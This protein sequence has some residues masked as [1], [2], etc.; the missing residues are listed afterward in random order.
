MDAA[1]RGSLLHDALSRFFDHAAGR[2]GSPVLLRAEH[3]A[4]AIPLAEQ[5]LDEALEDAR[6]KRWLGSELL[7][8]PK[9]LEL[10]RI[11]R[12]YL[13]WEI[14]Q[15]ER[16]FVSGRGGLPRRIR[17]GVHSHEMVLGEIEFCRGD[18]RIKFRGFVDRVEVGIDTRFD[19]G[20][21]VAAVDYK[22]TVWSCP[23]A[24]KGA[25]WTDGVVLQVP[26]Y[27]EALKARF[28]G[29]KTARVE[30]RAL[31]GKK[32]VHQLELY[33]FDKNSHRAVGDEE[34]EAKLEAALDAVADHVRT[35][36]SG[37][38]PVRPAESCGCPSFCHAIEICRVAGGPKTG[39]WP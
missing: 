4:A 29:A 30:Y 21:Y 26:L 20:C 24:G 5:S 19:A 17:T 7:L 13:E 10:W 33:E 14:E 16:M 34:G 8:G 3:A 39:D 38:F 12:G 23:G 32:V 9:R 36:R 18:I 11:L 28:P 6:G 37:Q 2:F 25:A 1:T 35:A 31:K 27:A 22:T 15:N